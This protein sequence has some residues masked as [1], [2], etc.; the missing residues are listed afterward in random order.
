MDS[1]SVIRIVAAVVFVLILGILVVRL[2][3]QKKS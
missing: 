2:K 1:V 3:K